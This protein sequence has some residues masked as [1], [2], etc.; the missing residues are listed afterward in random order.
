M[1]SP[2]SHYEDFYENLEKDLSSIDVDYK[3]N[4]TK[5]KLTHKIFNTIVKTNPKFLVPIIFTIV[6]IIL[7]YSKPSFI[8][9][10]DKKTKKTINKISY[11]KLLMYSVIIVLPVI[12]F[13]MLRFK[14]IL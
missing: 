9:Q 8:L 12:I 2:I 10:K 4:S 3:S 13:Y 5:P 6:L 11:L 7:Y 14:L 1:T